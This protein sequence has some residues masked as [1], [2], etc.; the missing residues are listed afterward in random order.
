MSIPSIVRLDPGRMT[1]EILLLD[2]D[3]ESFL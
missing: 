1:G 3:E 2:T